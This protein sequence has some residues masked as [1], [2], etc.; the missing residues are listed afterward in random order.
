MQL[1]TRELQAQRPDAAQ[2]S[3]QDNDAYCAQDPPQLSQNEHKDRQLQTQH[4][5][6]R[7]APDPTKSRI[8]R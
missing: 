6:E 8:Q 3:K 7:Y 5:H 4:G 1:N 2:H